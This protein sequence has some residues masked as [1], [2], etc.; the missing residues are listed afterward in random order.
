MEIILCYIKNRI[1]LWDGC[2]EHQ[3]HIDGASEA[4][5]ADD[6]Q[7]YHIYDPARHDISPSLSRSCWR[8]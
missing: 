5:V 4:A 8:A 7:D 1:L 6:I 2:N 3:Y